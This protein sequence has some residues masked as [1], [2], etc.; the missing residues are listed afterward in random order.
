[1]WIA[2]PGGI[3]VYHIYCRFTLFLPGLAYF[4]CFLSVCVSHV[5]LN[6]E[7]ILFIFTIS[8]IVGHIGFVPGARLLMGLCPCVGYT[9]VCASSQVICSKIRTHDA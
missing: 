9:V 2:C 1:M 6:K 3:P 4:N 8:P 5:P 7:S